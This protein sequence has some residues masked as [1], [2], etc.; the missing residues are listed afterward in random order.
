MRQIIDAHAVLSDPEKR[1]AYNREWDAQHPPRPPVANQP[2]SPRPTP[3]QAKPAPTAHPFA[4]GPPSQPAAGK[5]RAKQ[6]SSDL[7]RAVTFLVVAIISAAGG[8]VLFFA[9]GK[10]PFGRRDDSGLIVLC[11]LAAGVY[12]GYRAWSSFQAERSL[13][14][15]TEENTA[16]AMSWA[17]KT[18]CPPV[19]QGCFEVPQSM[20]EARQTCTWSGHCRIG[21]IVLKNDRSAEPWEVWIDG[22]TGLGRLRQRSRRSISAA[23]QGKV[24]KA[25]IVRYQLSVRHRRR[26]C[27]RR[28]RRGRLR[29]THPPNRVN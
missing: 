23:L 14:G 10:H 18:A 2:P 4:S 15:L 3:P 29:S 25:G 8:V 27:R 24:E 19:G 1:R 28:T 22:R 12:F 13:P 11:C 17:K 21:A 5:E 7:G 6:W 16:Q 20:M 26:G 9:G